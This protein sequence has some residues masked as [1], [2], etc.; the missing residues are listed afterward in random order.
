MP[1]RGNQAPELR[2]VSALEETS[3]TTLD[4]YVLWGNVTTLRR[5]GNA[6]KPDSRSFEPVCST[7]VA[8][9]PRLTTQ[10]Y[11]L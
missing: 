8:P 1:H 7:H 5:C 9:R 6:A 10:S 4:D 3:R 2:R 11:V